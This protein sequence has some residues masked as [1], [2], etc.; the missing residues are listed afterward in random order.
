MEAGCNEVKCTWTVATN[1]GC[2]KETLGSNFGIELLI[3]SVSTQS[4]RHETHFLLLFDL[5]W[6]GNKP[7]SFYRSA[8]SHVHTMGAVYGLNRSIAAKFH[9][10]RKLLNERI[11]T[12]S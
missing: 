8:S 7:S 11:E 12:F 5:A 10:S 9:F 4:P 1:E 2:C 6:T 3:R